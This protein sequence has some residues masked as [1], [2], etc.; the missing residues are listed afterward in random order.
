LDLG[1]G[2]A[3][4]AAAKETTMKSVRKQLLGVWLLCWGMTWAAP[5][6]EE[7]YKRPLFD[8]GYKDI[9]VETPRTALRWDMTTSLNLFLESPSVWGKHGVSLI[10]F[11]QASPER[12]RVTM[13][14]VSTGSAMLYNVFFELKLYGPDGIVEMAVLKQTID[15]RADVA[16]Q[17]V[18]EIPVDSLSLSPRTAYT[19]LAFSL[20][21][22]RGCIISGELR[23]VWM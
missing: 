14:F 22:T 17:I 16:R 4:L 20:T 8:K 2:L 6:N 19:S 23:R 21:I 15:R 5:V 11:E 3:R 1:T 18:W 12:I 10:R 7:E 9:A 13:D